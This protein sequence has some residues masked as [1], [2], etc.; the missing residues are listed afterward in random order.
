MTSEYATYRPTPEQ[1]NSDSSVQSQ[2]SSGN[3]SAQLSATP[4]S[5]EPASSDT[6]KEKGLAIVFNYKVA[7]GEERPDSYFYQQITS[8]IDAANIPAGSVGVP[9]EI[10]IDFTQISKDLHI[11]DSTQNF[12]LGKKGFSVTV[13]GEVMKIAATPRES[14][15]DVIKFCFRCENGKT[16][17]TG[18]DETPYFEYP[19][20]LLINPHPRDLWQNLPVK[21]YEGYQNKDYDAQGVSVEYIPAKKG[22]ASATPAKSIEVIAASQRGRSHAHV[23]KPRDDCFYFDFDKETGW[24]FVAVAD[25]AGSAKYSRKGAEIACQTVISKLRSAL[26]QEF[27]K[28][29][30]NSDLQ[31]LLQWGEE[32][33]AANGKLDGS[34]EN[35]FLAKTKLGDVFHQSV[36]AAHVAIVEEAKKRNAEKRDDAKTKDYHTTL[37]CAA[38]R[39]FSELSGWFIVSYWV[40]DGGAAIL[41]WNKTERVLVLGEPDGGEFA[42]QTRFLTMPEEINAAPIRKRLRFSFCDSFEAMVLVTDGITDPFFPSEAAVVDEP[43]WLEFYNDKLKKGCDEEKNGCKELFDEAISPQEK[44]EAL[45][46]WLDF[47]SKGNHD[48]RTILVVKNK[49]L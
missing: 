39:Y 48:D 47:W 25:G 15:D 30:I 22:F 12:E 17:I 36:Y 10:V 44:S 29:Y 2:P 9:Y 27:N 14:I 11:T 7:D 26:S 45:L 13:S 43:R 1:T 6:L 20:P 18:K 21:D 42:G 16:K 3:T 5:D 40:G 8:R 23:G 19:K 49:E 31:L 4:Q 33:V 35:E 28:T 41:R 34:R 37:L 24:N 46:K 32:F 38:F